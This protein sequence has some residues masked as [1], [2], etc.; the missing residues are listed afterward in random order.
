MKTEN[1]YNISM[2]GITTL[3]SLS[4]D[5]RN[6]GIKKG[7]RLFVH[8]SF[9]KLGF[10]SKESPEDVV[11]LLKGVLGEEGTLGMPTFSFSFTPDDMYDLRKSPS[12]VGVISE[13]FRKSDGVVRSISP[14]HSVAF[15]GKDA[16]FCARST[17][18]LP[19][20]SMMGPFGKLYAL[21]FKILMLACGLAPNSTLHA[22]EH[23]AELPY[24]KNGV[25]LCYSLHDGYTDGYLQSYMPIGHRDFYRSEDSFNAKY[26]K[27]LKRRNSLI[28]GKAGNSISYLMNTRSLVDIC[29]ESLDKTPD[30]FLCDKKDCSSCCGN[31]Y[32]FNAWKRR[33]GS[34]WGNV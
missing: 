11:S 22:I 31:R 33:G 6:L 2:S 34:L 16:D 9:K 1:N 25:Q 27:L 12:K 17:C 24:C 28:S 7:D 14:S 19:P 23:W 15:W 30:L 3:E 21:D 26:A 18:G 8:A 29:M 20:Y 10:G 5:I 32:D 4:E 13:A